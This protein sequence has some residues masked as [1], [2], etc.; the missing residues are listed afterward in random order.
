MGTALTDRDGDQ[1]TPEVVEVEGAMAEGAAVAVAVAVEGEGA[2]VV[3]AVARVHC[4]RCVS[5]IS[6]CVVQVNCHIYTKDCPYYGCAYLFLLVVNF[7]AGA[8]Y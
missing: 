5:G 4:I 2:V 6:C 1:D 8:I 7:S 3:A